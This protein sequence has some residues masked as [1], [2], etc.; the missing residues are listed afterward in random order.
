MC[1]CFPTKPITSTK[2]YTRW[3]RRKVRRL[4]VTVTDDFEDIGWWQKA[5]DASVRYMTEI[6]WHDFCVSHVVSIMTTAAFF[7]RSKTRQATTFKTIRKQPKSLNKSEQN[8]RCAQND[9]LPIDPE[10]D[11][12]FV[13]VKPSLTFPA[14]SQKM[15]GQSSLSLLPRLCQC[16]SKTEFNRYTRAKVILRRV[17]VELLLLRHNRESRHLRQCWPSYHAISR[18]H[19]PWRYTTDSI[20]KTWVHSDQVTVPSHVVTYLDAT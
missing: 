19:I 13:L 14:C 5:F 20:L 17:E 10:E 18:G 12:L 16:V 11:S 15:V 4:T 2:L 8:F 7:P 6:I 3:R 9:V 1:Y